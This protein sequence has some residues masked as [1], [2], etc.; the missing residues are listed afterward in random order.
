MKYEFK[1]VDV[2]TNQPMLGNPL[3]VFPDARGLNDE[4]MQKI[5]RELNLS[6]TTFVFP[7]TRKDCVC[8]I[9]IFTPATELPFA[10]H[11]TLGTCSVLLNKGLLPNA[12][13]SFAVEENI[14]AV[15]I[16]VE[17]G[18]TQKIWLTTPEIKAGPSFDG[19]K[20]AQALGIHQDQLLEIAPQILNAGNPTLFIALTNREAVDSVR[21]DS[22]GASQ[23][24]DGYNKP[25]CF[26]VFAL[27]QEGVYSR[28]FVPD[29][30]IVEDPA[31]GSAAGPLAQYLIQNGL[32]KKSMG[33]RFIHE[34]G[35]KMGRRSLIHV[36]I[37]G[38]EDKPL[39]EVGG[40]VAE[41]A[42]CSLNL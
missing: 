32:L 40:E 28:M 8:K 5:A 9:K 21:L 35:V 7:S 29:Y 16:R 4:V 2:F 15:E 20:C 31:T 13:D 14:G 39:F 33:Y 18:A 38:S 25:I 36:L 24:K 17:R 41:F 3:A 1:I 12:S 42:E 22:V 19:K 34:Q 37:S 27:T 10:G 11:P 23:I 6:E 30:G 26:M